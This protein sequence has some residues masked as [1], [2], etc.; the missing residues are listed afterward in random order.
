[1]LELTLQILLEKTWVWFIGPKHL[2]GTT[3]AL[4]PGSC[5]N[6]LLSLSTCHLHLQKCLPRTGWPFTPQV[7]GHWDF[8]SFCGFP[9]H[10]TTLHIKNI[11]YSVS[12][13]NRGHL[14]HISMPITWNDMPE[15]LRPRSDISARKLTW[16]AEL[17]QSQN[18]FR[19][20]TYIIHKVTHR[21]ICVYNPLKSENN[22]AW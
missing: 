21:Q 17:T 15:S 13:G 4:S 22:W 8:L 20:S 9:L 3:G 12:T 6:Q 11:H 5:G 2:E 14:S 18:Y 19:K 10:Y 1:M 7:W 16:K